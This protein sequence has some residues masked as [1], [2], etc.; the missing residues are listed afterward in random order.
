MGYQE[1]LPPVEQRDLNSTEIMMLS[2]ASVAPTRVNVSPEIFAKL[3]HGGS[4]APE[5]M[6]A[7]VAPPAMAS[8][9]ALLEE[10]AVE[11]PGIEE[12]AVEAPVMETDKKKKSSKM[13]RSAKKTKNQ[14]CC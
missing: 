4:L 13:K 6:A 9:Q 3:L 14:G 11:A 8:D 5:E 7:L 12:P 10:P 1:T 2:S